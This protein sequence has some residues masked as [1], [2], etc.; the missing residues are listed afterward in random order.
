M[1]EITK[2]AVIGA[3]A[4]GHGIA[5]VFAHSG[6]QVAL[7]D[8][9]EKI[10]NAAKSHISSNLSFLVKHKVIVHQCS[11]LRLHARLIGKHQ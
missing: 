9:D 2:T 11:Y 1:K 8:I 10:L 7:C 5:Q 4:M 3:G 6:L